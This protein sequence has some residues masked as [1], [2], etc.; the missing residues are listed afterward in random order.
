MKNRLEMET[1]EV[2]G[3]RELSNDIRDLQMNFMIGLMNRAKDIREEGLIWT[4]FKLQSINQKPN[5]IHLGIPDSFK[6]GLFSLFKQRQNVVDLEVIK[7]LGVA[8]FLNKMRQSMTASS[9][10][11]YDNSIISQNNMTLQNINSYQ[12]SVTNQNT[13]TN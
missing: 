7:D 6:D 10:N 12:N 13:M 4:L 2:N 3:L 5:V 11:Q 8:K 9:Q 1:M